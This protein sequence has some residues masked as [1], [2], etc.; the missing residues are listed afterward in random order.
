MEE[1]QSYTC[2][3]H[4]VKIYSKCVWDP[5]DNP[6]E[7]SQRTGKLSIM[8]LFPLPDAHISLNFSASLK[9]FVFLLF[10]VHVFDESLVIHFSQ[11]TKKGPPLLQKRSL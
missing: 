11:S 2:S 4:N 10:D 8:A 3:G 6:G 1:Q 9:F 5:E 7:H